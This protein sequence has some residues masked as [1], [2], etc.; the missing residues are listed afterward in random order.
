ME[1]IPKSPQMFST[2]TIDDTPIPQ[3]SQQ[4]DLRVTADSTLRWKKHL[5]DV[6]K[7]AYQ[8]LYFIKW[9]TSSSTCKALKRAL[10][11]TLVRSKLSYC[12]PLWRPCHTLYI[13]KLEQVQRHATE[14]LVDDRS[15]NY[16]ERLIKLHILPLIYCF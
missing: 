13:T 7:R 9:H 2:Y 4:R 16:K 6:Y 11:L 10:Y 3:V 12:S 15:L 8:S 5:S 14:F 1:A